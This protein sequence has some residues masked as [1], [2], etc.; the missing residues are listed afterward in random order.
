MFKSILRVLFVGMAIAASSPAM[1]GAGQAPHCG[2][3]PFAR[4]SD[5][6]VFQ[7]VARGTTCETARAVAG[8][9][10]PSRFRGGDPQ[11]AANG[12]SCSGRSEQIG[13]AGK[14]VVRFLCTRQHGSISFLR[15]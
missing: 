7:I 12:F 4:Q 8:A 1:A 13:G 14:Q 2:S 15:G 10:R 3:V 6:G 5:D 9:S 11:Y